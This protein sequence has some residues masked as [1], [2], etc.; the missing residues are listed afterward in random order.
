MTSTSHSVSSDRLAVE[1]VT[2]RPLTPDDA[3]EIARVAVRM[4]ATLEEVLGSDGRALYSS[5]WLVDRVHFHLDKERSNGRIWIAVRESGGTIGHVIARME[6][7]EPNGPLGLIST[8]YVAPSWRRLAVASRLLECAEDW[9]VGQGAWQMATDTSDTNKP[10]IRLFE[11]RGYS[12][13]Y[14]A[15]EK[16]MLRLSRQVDFRT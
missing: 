13:T 15:L 12:T 6:M 8:I 3:R 14:R 11:G 5:R 10:L 7:D 4:R 2:I 16:K 1:D 9:L